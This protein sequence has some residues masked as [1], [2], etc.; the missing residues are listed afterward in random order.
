MHFN[1]FIYSQ[2]K[3]MKKN[4]HFYV[5]ID[6]SKDK[7]DYCI[8][9]DP[10]AV[11]QYVYGIVPNNEKGIKQLFHAVKKQKLD[12]ANGLFAM[13]NT[14]VYTMPLCFSLQQVSIDY[15]VIPPMQVKRSKGI[16]RG[17]SDKADAKDIALYAI[18]HLHIITLAVLPAEDLLELRLLLAERVKIVK[19]IRAFCTTKEN[20]GFMPGKIAK[21]VL[22]HN[23]K[24]V[25]F[26]KE[27]LKS[28]EAAIGAIVKGNATFKTQEQLLL[29]V[30]G[31]GKQIA[32]NLIA[33]TNAFTAFKTWRKFACYCGVAPF[34]Y[35]SGSSIKGRTKVHPVADRKMKA[36]LNI[37]ALAAKKHDTE[38]RQY[39][40]RKIKEGKNKMSVLNAL[41]CKIVA[42]VFA[43]ISRRTP[44]VDTLKAVA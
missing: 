27:Q 37:A 16:V 22:A 38:L 4:Y 23:K 36:L 43:V 12:I 13:E 44:F 5:G 39:F 2:I 34:E 21:T 30:P 42:R 31:V 3:V 32:V 29:G 8:I 6:I 7:L 15:T 18:A 35:S 26:L 25:V 41:R 28:I 17:K 19:A 1:F 10:G 9:T 24:T 40:E 11:S 33:A 14:G 20:K